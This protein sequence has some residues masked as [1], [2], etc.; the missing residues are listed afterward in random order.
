MNWRSP[1][2]HR[3]SQWPVHH[4]DSNGNL[5]PLPNTSYETFFDSWKGETLYK[6]FGNNGK[7][8][9]HVYR[10]ANIYFE[11]SGRRRNKVGG[12]LCHEICSHCSGK[13]EQTTRSSKKKCSNR[14]CI[15][16]FETKGHRT[17]SSS[18]SSS[19]SGFSSKQKEN[20]TK[21]SVFEF[22]K[23]AVH[24]VSQK[25]DI[26][27]T[28]KS[29]SKSSSSSSSSP[30][31][32]AL[33]RTPSLST[34]VSSSLPSIPIIPL[35]QNA[36]NPPN[37]PGSNGIVA[38]A[39]TVDLTVSTDDDE[40]EDG[41]SDDGDAKNNDQGDSNQDDDSKDKDQDDDSDDDD[42]KDQDEEYIG[43]R[44]AK[45]FTEGV[46]MGTVR[47]SHM[48]NHE[49]HFRI[50]YDDD[51]KEDISRDDLPEGIALAFHVQDEQE[52]RDAKK[53]EEDK[54]KKKKEEA[55]KFN[56]KIVSIFILV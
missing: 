5:R 7:K 46:F 9:L 1:D 4:F 6:E 22:P 10:K 43:W 16:H 19:S 27:N 51:D 36:P 13:L 20:I 49:Q 3:G 25:K 40:K 47:S 45:R 39:T 26:A 31:P 21:L 28:K 18:S 33:T 14:D 2:L 50:V 48:I 29:I 23:D 17:K 42:D 24:K 55:E 15:S 53:M 41:D 44:F 30:S 52:R 37:P 32:P 35:P 34:S 8:I 56:K 38:S 11:Q 12:I 54:K